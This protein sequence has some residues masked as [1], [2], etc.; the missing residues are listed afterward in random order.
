M[1][2][3]WWITKFLEFYRHAS[4]IRVGNKGIRAST[5][6]F[7]RMYQSKTSILIEIVGY[8]NLMS[9]RKFWVGVNLVVMQK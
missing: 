4:A 3:K 9:G 8:T 5:H 7:Q 1:T 6:E 2:F